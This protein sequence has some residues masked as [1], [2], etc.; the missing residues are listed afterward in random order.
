[1]LGNELNCVIQISRFKHQNSTQLFL[2][3][4][5]RLSLQPSLLPIH[6]HRGVVG[7]KS[8]ASGKMS[9]LPQLVV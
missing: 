3:R 1:M 9:V 4:T 8:F 5:D 2:P 6:G 7:L